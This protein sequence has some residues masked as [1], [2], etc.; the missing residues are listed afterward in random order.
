LNA[1]PGAES[2]FSIG[3]LP[4]MSLFFNGGSENFRIRSNRLPHALH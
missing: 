3:P 2:N 1:I 4:Q